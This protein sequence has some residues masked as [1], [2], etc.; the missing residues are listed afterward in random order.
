[1]LRIV[2]LEGGS[3]IAD[4]RRPAMQVP[5][6]RCVDNIEAFVAGTPRNCVA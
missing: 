3:L 6:D 1:M 4:I 2:Q 5:A